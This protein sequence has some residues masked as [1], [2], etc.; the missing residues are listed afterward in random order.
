MGN[1][2]G[3]SFVIGS[4]VSVNGV[5]VSGRTLHKN[6]KKYELPRYSNIS[7]RNNEVYLDGKRF[8][9]KETP[10][11]PLGP[12]CT[13]KRDYTVTRFTLEGTSDTTIQVTKGA[14]MSVEVT[15]HSSEADMLNLL[16]SESE[17]KLCDIPGPIKVSIVL[18][19]SFEA[20]TLKEF[21]E[22]HLDGVTVSD[23]NVNGGL[24]KLSGCTVHNFIG[25]SVKVETVGFLNTVRRFNV[26]N[27][28]ERV[29]VHMTLGHSC[30][31]QT[32][33][34]TVDVEALPGS[35]ESRHVTAKTMSGSVRL[36]TPGKQSIVHTMSGSVNVKAAGDG[37]NFSTMSGSVHLTRPGRRC[38]VKTMSGSL[39]GQGQNDVSFTTMSGSNRYQKTTA[40]VEDLSD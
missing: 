34:G 19:E 8:H 17:L 33:S 28:F 4:T 18:P 21:Q 3:S 25:D 39:K 11:V 13:T 36:V 35:H 23:V 29:S 1:T 40:Q 14:S 6:G 22:T 20:L 30:Y 38:T 9:P 5:V 16:S 26:T 32:Q 2:V 15:H 37:G 24:V 12:A 7:I 27:T 31:I 10:A